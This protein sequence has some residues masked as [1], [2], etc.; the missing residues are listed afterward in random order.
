[1][2]L[3]AKLIGFGGMVTEAALAGLVIFIAAGVLV[4]DPDGG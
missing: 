4:W 2:K 1:M 3:R